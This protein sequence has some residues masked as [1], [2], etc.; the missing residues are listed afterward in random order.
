MTSTSER[1]P[2]T[3]GAPD[4]PAAQPAA[5]RRW[6]RRDPLAALAVLFMATP[7]VVA[8]IW[9]CTQTRWYPSGDRALIELYT[10]DIGHHAVLL[11]PYSRFGWHHPGPALYELLV[12]P[13]RLTGSNGIGLMLGVVLIN[14]AAAAGIALVA[15]RR[16]GRTL[17]IW[18]LIVL[19][20]FLHALGP[21]QLTDPFNPFPPVLVL[22]LLLLLL[23]SVALGDVWMLPWAAVAA[24]F[25][26]QSHIGSLITIVGLVGLAGIFL[27]VQIVA[28]RND[29]EQRR[30]WRRVLPRVIGVTV[31]LGFVLWLPPII[32]QL[33][34]HP[35][36]VTL[37]REYAARAK[38]SQPANTVTDVSLTEIGWI[39]GLNA[40]AHVT[41]SLFTRMSR[42]PGELTIGVYLVAMIATV[43]RRR[44]AQV[45]LGTLVG[46]SIGLAVL[47]ISRLDG[48]PAEYLVRWATFVGFGI[49]VFAGWV[50]LDALAQV[51]FVHARRMA[52]AAVGVG[53]VAILAV[54][55]S[56]NSARADP[57]DP[58]ASNRI[59]TLTPRVLRAVKAKSA[60]PVVIGEGRGLLSIDAGSGLALQLEKHGVRVKFE[61]R[62]KIAYGARRTDD[63]QRSRT[64]ITVVTDQ[65][66]RGTPL[67]P[68]A[69]LIAR[70]HDTSVFESPGP[71]VTH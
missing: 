33:T 66:A 5:P 30:R 71:A 36:N 49:W 2:M 46:G 23:W 65:D 57:P 43:V 55:L 31:L 17:L 67:P 11:G 1:P 58:V 20:L 70:S 56:V 14:A 64:R 19:G 45:V 25:A 52:G 60:Q 61:P 35:G 26:V 51:D 59:R 62:Q 47:S 37:M 10:R 42:W 69:K 68:G 54:V 4:A 18:A 12:L 22:G 24:T 21:Q 8:M 28:T 39:T 63:W 27:V 32:E 34:H 44:R 15:Y 41:R 13:Y 29:A 50:V 6:Y 40:G 3:A 53:I 7:F 48:L 9:C 38:P 16:G